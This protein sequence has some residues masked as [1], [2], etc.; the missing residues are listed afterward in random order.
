MGFRNEQMPTSLSYGYTGGP[1]FNTDIVV[2]DS[3]HEERVSRW[4]TPR[5]SWEVSRN[6]ASKINTHELQEFW[7]TCAGAAYGFRFKD[8]LDFSSNANDGSSTPTDTDQ[9]IGTADGSETQFQLVKNYTFGSTTY[10]RVITHPVSGSV[11]IAVGG[12]PVTTGWTVDTETGVV[13]FSVAPSS[14]YVT[15][16]YLFDVPARFAPSDEQLQLRIDAYDAHTLLDMPIIEVIDEGDVPE[17]YDPGGGVYRN[18]TDNF[19]LTLSTARLWVLNPDAAGHVGILPEPINYG[20]GG[21]YF[22][23]FND[24]TTDTVAIQDSAGGSIGTVPVKA[25]GVRGQLFIGLVDNGTGTK[26][27]IGWQ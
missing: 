11:V 17:T 2:T 26:T 22:L 21:P 3:G 20:S 1:R 24:S 25:A 7:L 27:W 5:W 6:L 19:T 8:W 4:Q 23:L 15:A 10:Q 14:G 13:T 9:I 18:V 16:G 12:S